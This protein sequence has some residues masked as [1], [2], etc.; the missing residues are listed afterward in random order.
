[1]LSLTKEQRDYIEEQKRIDPKYK[2]ELCNTFSELGRCNYGFK[3]RYAHGVEELVP[4]VTPPYYKQ[5]IC[6]SFFEK[7]Y[8][9]YG[10]RCNY[11]HNKDIY[12]KVNPLILFCCIYKF[13]R[14]KVFREITQNSLG[15]QC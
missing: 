1:M 15:E 5:R 13:N 14:L 4:K 3:C 7:G 6:K 2:T 11:I 10:K 9:K 8:C 12:E